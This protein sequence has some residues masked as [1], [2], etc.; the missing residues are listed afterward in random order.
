[1]PLPECPHVLIL[2]A[3]AL[4]GFYG[5]KLHQ[6]GLRVSVVCRSDFDTVR[7]DGIHVDGLEG[8]CHFHPH[9]VLRRAAELDSPAD[10]IL[11]ATKS[12]PGVPVPPLLE[13]AVSPRTTLL[14]LQNGI[15]IEDDTAR[16]FPNN[17]LLS[18]LAF[19]CASR[20]APGHIRHV[21][22]GHLT[23]GRHPRGDSS[24]AH[25]LAAQWEK[26]GIPCRVSPQIVTE[27][28]KKLVWNAPFNPISVLAG[29][30]TTRQMMDDPLLRNLARHVMVEVCEVAAAAGH[31]LPDSVVAEHLEATEA[32]K[33]YKTSMLL[34]YE[35]G[36]E[37]EIH[38]ILGRTLEIAR[39][40]R[41]ATPHLETLYALLRHA[42]PGS[43]PA[44]GAGGA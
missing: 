13:G 15:G 4:G 5:A 31:P 6:A 10:V 29:G 43:T 33:P 22:F 8:T 35:S 21:C 24:T 40:H 28:W 27:R 36:R 20:T 1:M 7:R 44:N 39:E 34:D 16:A 26:A 30:A 18:G 2:G 23:I 14:L 17:E 12:L 41:V 32:M 25:W 42:K 19:I 37:A 38:A 11:V 9:R 3:G